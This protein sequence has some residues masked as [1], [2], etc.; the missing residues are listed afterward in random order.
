MDVT[1]GTRLGPYEIVGPLGAGGMGQV[2]RARDTRLKRDVALKVIS[3]RIADRPDLR[4]RFH[5]EATAVAAL[6]H[7]NICQV[8]DVGEHAGIDFIVIELVDGETLASRLSRGA[9]P[10]A[11]AIQLARELTAAAGAAHRAGVIHRDIKPSNIM[12]TRAGIKLLDFGLARQRST[13]DVSPA[14]ST[15]APLSDPL[16]LTGMVLG[17]WQY[18]SPEQLR[19]NEADARS[20]VFSIGVVLYEAFTG[21]RLFQRPT[22]EASVIA[23]LEDEP[24]PMST[25][26]SDVPANIDRVVGVCL[27]KDPAD[28]WQSAQDLHHALEAN[29][30]VLP[31]SVRVLS[32]RTAAI[33][34]AAAIIVAVMGA[35]LWPRGGAIGDRRPTIRSSI[36]VSPI[37][38]PQNYADLQF[39]PDG[40]TFI[41]GGSLEGRA[42]LFRYDLA[43]ARAIPIEGTVGGGPP[44]LSPDGNWLGFTTPAGGLMKMPIA[45]GPPIRIAD[46]QQGFGASWGDDGFIVYSDRPESGLK[47]VAASGGT[48]TT[49]TVLTKEDEG[50][51][52]RYPEV[53]PGSRRILFSV[54]TGPEE[55]ARVAGLNLDTGQ[56]KDLI[57]G[58][59]SFRYLKSGHIAYVANDALFVVRF[60][61]DRLE[62]TGTPVRIADGV[63]MAESP[64]F[65]FSPNGDLMYLPS[66]PNGE[67]FPVSL[68]S[69]NGDVERIPGL[70]GA[71]DT[72]RFSP[73]GTKL[74][75]RRGGTK[76]NVWVYDFERTTLT[77]VTYGR[78]QGSIWTRDGRITTP[79]GGPGDQR[80]VIRAADGTGDDTAPLTAGGTEERPADWTP[81]G[82]TLLYARDGDIWTVAP[83]RAQPAPVWTTTFTEHLVRLS[84]DGRLLTYTANDTGRNE[85]YVSSF[86]GDPGRVQISVQGGAG[87]AWSPDGRRVY[88][89]GPTGE[90]NV[91]GIFSS[92]ITT[93]PRL[94]ASKPRLMFRNNGFSNRFDLSPD[95]KRFVMVEFGAAPPRHTLTMVQNWQSLLPSTSRD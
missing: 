14:N 51:D 5:R 93:T 48:P 11:D 87:S 84:P 10:I 67:A 29:A 60:D 95:G 35:A 33:V 31:A 78:Y 34:A 24:A 90:P 4:E 44:F 66:R 38:F 41:F 21:K 49:I 20:D 17:T 3:D 59:F 58:A 75:L 9:L 55:S 7:P 46:Q 86:R 15:Q 28:R 94:S 52:H 57:R 40:H 54:G 18:M 47:R 68:I 79:R 62:V 22:H 74:L 65:A 12:L 6:N 53:L 19:G 13:A 61:S 56:R 63:E 76:S 1:A 82:Q 69:L 50:E 37:V 8:Y 71:F 42:Q 77:R 81:D 36:D 83:G 2:Y 32:S 64:E 73:D 45:G 25:L 89:R 16:T 23:I 39:L 27:A 92:D 91:F 85:I 43:T 88:F 72:P 26:R 30:D 80:I 70:T